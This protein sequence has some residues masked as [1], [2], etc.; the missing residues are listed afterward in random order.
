[1]VSAGWKTLLM[2]TQLLS[3]VW[4]RV[5]D[6]RCQATIHPL[7]GTFTSL[8][9]RPLK[10]STP[11]VTRESWALLPF[12]ASSG[13]CDSMKACRSLG[14]LARPM[15]HLTF[16]PAGRFHPVGQESFLT[17]IFPASQVA[18]GW[19]VLL[20][21]DSSQLRGPGKTLYL[22]GFSACSQVIS[23]PGRILPPG[24]VFGLVPGEGEGAGPP[25]GGKGSDLT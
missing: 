19:R 4:G 14:S 9:P 12:P 20:S 2:G 21:A 15:N 10:L 23:G 17:F 6:W 5:G 16:E 13:V 7:P 22:G 25:P 11:L 1:M 8:P 24:L 3:S 18:S